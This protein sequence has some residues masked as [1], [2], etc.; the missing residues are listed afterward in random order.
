[1]PTTI[2]DVMKVL[3]NVAPPVYQESYDN[4]GLIVGDPSA[5]VTGVVCSLD[6][7]EEVVAEAAAKGCNLVVAHHPIVFKG[8]KRLNGSN[9]VERTVIRAIKEG[10]AI[11][12]IHTNLDNVYHRGVNAK[13]AERLG[14][15]NTSILAPKTVGH[16]LSLRVEAAQAGALQ[17]KLE[18]AGAQRIYITGGTDRLRLEGY[19]PDALIGATEALLRSEGINEYE[20]VKVENADAAFGSGMVG[21]LPEAMGEK[22]FMDYLIERMNAPLIRHTALRNQPVKKVALCGGSGSFLLRKA[23]ACGADVFITG[24]FKYHE[25]FDAEGKIV[26]MDIGHFESEQFTIELLRD[27]IGENFSTFA[28]HLTGVITNPVNYYH[29]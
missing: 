19:L 22:D 9:Y 26:I 14:L 7:T 15:K 21:E 12:A 29:K 5:E 20:L 27:I 13:I 16:K 3:E 18:Q 2:R 6:A 25:F 1:M 17:A 23:I 8:L 10:V 11:Y 4:A 28:L 24:D